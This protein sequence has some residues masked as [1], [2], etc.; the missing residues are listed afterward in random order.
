MTF[1]LAMFA[2]AAAVGWLAP[3]HLRRW[4]LRRRD[5]LLLIV[6][7]LASMASVLLA[8]ATGVAALL[9]PDHEPGT[10]LLSA[11]HHCWASIQHGSPPVV[12]EFT[13][14]FGLGL[15][16]A[17]AARVAFVAGRGVRRRARAQRE[18]LAV[19]RVAARREPGSPDTLWLAHDRPLAFSLTGRHGI[20]VATEG[21]TRH[22][23]APAVDAVLAHER[24]HLA[25]R[26]HVLIAAADALRAA[27]PFVPLF[28]HAPAAVRELVE[29]AADATA[30]RRCGT[31]AVRSAL[32]SV[33]G[34]GTPEAA[35][36]MAR[37]AVDLRLARL[38]LST[39]APRRFRRAVSCGLTGLTAA[40]VPFVVSTGLLLG[41]AT[42]ACPG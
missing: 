13:G 10:T 3:V 38:H 35:L 40:A 17:F 39:G 8:T 41:I 25:G 36:A 21:L 6:A 7:W 33:S 19:L 9:Q 24:A 32:V 18:R 1:A 28:R 30:V 23:S 12:E 27:L 31:A 26:H 20:I 37:D 34:H 4:D 14:A 2:G 5:P 11:L 29:L 16:A 42:L 22:L 15:L